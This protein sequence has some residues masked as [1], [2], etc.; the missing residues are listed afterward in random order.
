MIYIIGSGLSSIAAA[1]ALVERAM[2]RNIIQ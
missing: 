2:Q 1:K